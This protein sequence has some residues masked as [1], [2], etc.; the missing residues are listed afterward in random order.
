MDPSASLTIEPFVFRHSTRQISYAPGCFA[1][2]PDIARDRAA[3][4]IAFVVDSFVINGPLEA[5]VRELIEANEF[6]TTIH[7]VPNR[8]PDTDSVAACHTMLKRAEPDMIVAIGGGSTMDT[9]KVARILLSNPCT[10]AEMASFDRHFQPH[11]TPFVRVPTP[12]FV[13]SSFF[14]NTFPSVSSV[15]SSRSVGQQSERTVVRLFLPAPV[16][17]ALGRCASNRNFDPGG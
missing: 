12:I 13:N 8:E 5:R 2:L 17:Q 1:R 9:A 10:L 15:V 14:R 7:G 4:R 3:K 6:A 11:P 16:Q